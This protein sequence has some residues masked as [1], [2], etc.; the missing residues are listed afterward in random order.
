MTDIKISESFDLEATRTVSIQ[1]YPRIVPEY[2]EPWSSFGTDDVSIMN[3]IFSN[4]Q[5]HKIECKFNEKKFYIKGK[6]E[7]LDGNMGKF[8][9]YLYRNVTGFLVEVIRKSGDI[10]LFHALYKQILIDLGLEQPEEIVS[11]L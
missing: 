1:E 11:P 9:I 4:L 8:S 3:S 7:S 10:L 6:F 2:V 5:K